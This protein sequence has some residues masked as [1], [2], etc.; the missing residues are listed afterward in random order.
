MYRIIKED[1]WKVAKWS[2]G[3]TNEIFICPENSSYKDRNFNV[4][5]SIATTNNEEK[6]EFTHLPG[7]QRFISKLEGDM[8]LSHYERYETDVEK[9]QIERFDGGWLTYS[10][11]KFKDFNLMLKDVRGDLYYGEL[12]G[13]VSLHLQKGAYL[14]FVYVIEGEFNIAEEYLE[15]SKNDLLI[16]DENI[17]KINAKNAKVFYG[18]A[19]KW[20]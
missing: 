3:E 19:K 17:F 11:G 12:D 14:T 13:E 6:S 16:S 1:E 4:R 15:L 2:N 20:E 8:F 7:V 9:Y 5:I 18:Y 10:Y